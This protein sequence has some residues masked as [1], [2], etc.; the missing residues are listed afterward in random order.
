MSNDNSDTKSTQHDPCPCCEESD[1]QRASTSDGDAGE[2]GEHED[3]LSTSRRG[4]LIG[5]SL[6]AAGAVA[7]PHIWVPN[8]AVAMTSMFGEVRH[9]LYIRLSGGF[10]FTAAFNGDVASEYNPFGLSENVPSGAEWGPSSL[11][12]RDGWV[13]DLSNMAMAGG[14]EAPALRPISEWANEIA[15]IP[16]VDH[17]PL[18]GSADGNHNTGLERYL[19]GYVGGGTSFFTMINYGL[20]N[21]PVLDENGNPQLPA[22]VLGNTGMARGTGKYAGYRP[23]VMTDG[24]F[25]Q[26][27]FIG[28]GEI[29]YIQ[30]A[31]HPDFDWTETI[32]RRHKRNKAKAL[33]PVVDAYLQARDA[34]D[35]FAAIFR[36]EALKINNGGEDLVDGISNA[37]LE[38]IMGSRGAA[39]NVRLAL[40][41]FHFGSPAVYLDQGGYDMH[42]GEESGLPRR[43]DELNRIMAGLRYVLKRMTH[44]EHGY[45][46]WDKTL[47][48]LGSE[49]GRTARG[50]KFNS[51][52]GSDHGGDLATRWMSMPF[53]GGPVSNTAGQMV[54][55]TTARDDLTA[56]GTVFSYRQVCK[57][58]MDALGCEHEEFF[59]A[60]EP[61]EDLWG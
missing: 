20:R 26:F 50:G 2:S 9:L 16:T 10:R 36:D 56:D 21:R 5:S 24:G 33:Q 23:P 42:S 17:E 41:L 6:L 46:Y 61:F 59:P 28:A 3:A 29:P 58:L 39:R 1:G 13:P 55:A 14:G 35:K 53:M 43:L 60:D 7:V 15:V 32:D 22:F 40:R 47:V 25:D 44:D 8:E 52:N 37:Q 27:G 11:L 18:A 34:T 19:T 51:A 4:F 49:F 54:G 30:P 12:G 57:T 48:V 31:D 38:A 45:S